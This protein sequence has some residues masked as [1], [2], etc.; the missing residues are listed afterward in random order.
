MWG[1]GEDCGDIPFQNTTPSN[2][3]RKD[4]PWHWLSWLSTKI[5]WRGKATGFCHYKCVCLQCVIEREA[6]QGG[7]HHQ[8]ILSPLINCAAEAYG[9]GVGACLHLWALS[10]QLG[11]DVCIYT[12]ACSWH[13][14]PS[15]HSNMEEQK[16]KEAE[17]FLSKGFNFLDD[18]IPKICRIQISIPELWQRAFHG[19]ERDRKLPFCKVYLP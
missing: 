17:R 19:E 12:E 7:C 15:G 13:L 10:E 3:F 9:V 18:L 8:Q 14:L 5:N 1:I 2:P 11:K 4:S 16:A 6:E